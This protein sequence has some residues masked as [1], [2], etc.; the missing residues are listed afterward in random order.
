MVKLFNPTFPRWEVYDDEPLV[1]NGEEQPVFVSPDEDVVDAF[2]QKTEKQGQ[3][4]TILKL[5]Q[6]YGY[7]DRVMAAEHFVLEL[8]ARI[9]DMEKQGIKFKK[10][11]VKEYYPDGKYKGYH[12]EYSL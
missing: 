8:S 6:K 5:I 10:S 3:C 7:V 4:N 9:C 1:R 2:M 12:K 11:T